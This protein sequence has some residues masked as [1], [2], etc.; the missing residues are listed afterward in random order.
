MGYAFQFIVGGDWS[1]FPAPPLEA[2]WFDKQLAIRH[3]VVGLLF[4]VVA[5]IDFFT[6]ANYP[7]QRDFITA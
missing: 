3:I 7:M 1:C 5:A 6:F 4:G 2:D